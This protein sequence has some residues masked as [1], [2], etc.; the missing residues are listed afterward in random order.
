MAKNDLLRA[1]KDALNIDDATMIQIFSHAGRTVGQSTI[2][3]L[4]KTEEEDDYIPC[5][6]PVLGFFL[7]GLIIHN[8]GQQENKPAAPEKPV[9]VLTNNTILKKLRIALNLKE[10]DL[11]GIL[12]SAGVT[13]SKHELTAL[14]RK[15]GHKH[16]KA[17]NNRFL[18]DFLKG[19]ALRNNSGI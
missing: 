7:D 12:A 10:D 8:R 18:T 6:D 17:C 15:E 14:F 1:I 3:A 5:N 13:V 2:T 11:I 9:A 4:T 16:Y 19:V